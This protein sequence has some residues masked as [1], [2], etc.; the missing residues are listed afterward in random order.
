[1]GWTLAFLVMPAV[2]S[3]AVGGDETSLE[4]IK[5]DGTRI[6][7]ALL[8]PIALLAGIYAAPFLSLWVGPEFVPYAWMLQ[9]FL[10]ATLPLVLSVVVQMAIGMG[11]IEVVAI[12]NLVGALV[13][14]PLSYYLTR[15]LGVS[16]VIWGTV[17]TTLFSNLLV[18]GVYVFRVLDIKYS[19]FLVRTLSA[20]FAGALALVVACWACRGVVP[21]G[22]STTAAGLMRA[23][24][25]LTNLSVG[26][27]AYMIGYFVTPAGRGDA[28]AI[29]RKLGR[30]APL[31]G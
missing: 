2:V 16:G 8:A 18:P 23:L 21:P 9:L 3:L 5:Y 7:V 20:P 22:P 10:V 19:T 24:P 12:S 25:F 11:K 17:L 26:T 27:I 14:L 1:M 28:R 13:N 15:R 30:R 29:A 31:D 4:R 6:L